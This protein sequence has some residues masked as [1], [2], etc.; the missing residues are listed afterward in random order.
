MGQQVGQWRSGQGQKLW[1]SMLVDT[2]EALSRS[3]L[4]GSPVS[5]SVLTALKAQLARPASLYAH[6]AS[7][8]SLRN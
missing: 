5:S 7:P 3:E 2:M 6:G 8:F 1:L 4:R